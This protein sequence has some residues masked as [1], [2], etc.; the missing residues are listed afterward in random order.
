MTIS[1]SAFG[2]PYTDFLPLDQSEALPALPRGTLLAIRPAH[3][4]TDE[5]ILREVERLQLA[6]AR[7]TFVLWLDLVERERVA[8]LAAAGGRRGIRG[9]VVRPLLDDALLRAQLTDPRDFPIDLVRWLE[10][11]GF[12]LRRPV[13]EM[14][15][16]AIGHAATCRSVAQL[17]A[18]SGGNLV[19]WRRALQHAGVGSVANF[20]QIL[21][22]LAIAIQIQREPTTALSVI[23]ERYAFYDGAAL[24]HRFA[25]V[26]GCPPSD[27]RRYLGWEWMVDA[28]LRRSGIVP[29]RPANELE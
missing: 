18:R 13:H 11:R 21:R 14:M 7:T 19:R 5:R 9:F 12:E 26:F 24:R 29:S 17:A 20:H 22:L 15:R 8:S 16:A 2:P 23:S 25:E 6:L 27:A 3:I 1:L 4:V 10:R 28:A